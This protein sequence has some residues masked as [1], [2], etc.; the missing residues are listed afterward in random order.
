MSERLSEHSIWSVVEDPTTSRAETIDIGAQTNNSAYVSMQNFSRCILQV[1]LGTYN[2]TDELDQCQ[3][4]QADTSS[5]GNVKDLTTSSSG[6]NYDTANKIGSD[7]DFVVVEVRGE[8]LALDVT[9]TSGTGSLPF[10]FVRALVTEDSDTGQDDCFAQL[11]RYGGYY[12]RKEL[13][14][15][16]SSTQVYVDTGT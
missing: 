4:Q 6:G 13:Q 16:A 5:G 15:A 9:A 2:S 10:F 1:E 12:M 11:I 3:L 14:G 7:G 8:D